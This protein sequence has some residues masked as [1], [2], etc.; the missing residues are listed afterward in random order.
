MS[1]P[2]RLSGAFGAATALAL[3]ACSSIKS[4]DGDRREQSTA[5]T[6]QVVAYPPASW[7]LASD[8]ELRRT[9]VWVSHIVIS[10]D[11][12]SL[13][14]TVFRP[15]GW[16]PEGTPEPRS[17]AAAFTR[18]YDVKGASE[19]GKRPQNREIGVCLHGITNPMVQRTERTVQAL[20]MLRQRALRID[21]KRCSEF[22][23]E[24]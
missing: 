3:V 5:P 12:S 21:V 4:S 6:T 7:R 24:R 2:K 23:G 20:E 15:P 13:A 11:K 1:R 14:G 8:D 16:N 9:V 18:A 19:I 17:E 22:F 10:F